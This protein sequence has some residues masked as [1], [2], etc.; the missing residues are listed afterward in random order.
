M[1]LAR[2]ALAAAVV[3]VTPASAVA[4]K[5]DSSGY[6]TTT[7]GARLYYEI[8]GKARDTVIVPGAALL[9]ASLSPLDVELTLVFYDPR[10]R[11]RSDWIP[12]S[13]RLTMD[14][15]IADLE[16]IRESLKISKAGIIGFSYLGLMT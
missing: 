8:Y 7:D 10:G 9:A 2:Y 1:R 12:E 13:K 16:A 5:P 3:A 14:N 4:Q 11:G 15:E 6:I